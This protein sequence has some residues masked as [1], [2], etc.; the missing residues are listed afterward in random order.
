MFS[1]SQQIGAMTH[2][3][4][5]CSN[6]ILCAALEIEARRSERIERNNSAMSI[7]NACS[8]LDYDTSA[9]GA[10]ESWR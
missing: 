5:E 9:A 3:K 8:R 4:H 1:H 6:G 2:G 10:H 7:D